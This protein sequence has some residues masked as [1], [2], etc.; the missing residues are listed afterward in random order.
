MRPNEHAFLEGD[1]QHPLT[2]CKWNG[3]FIREQECCGVPP[4]EEILLQTNQYYRFALTM[5]T[6]QI[7]T[8]LGDCDPV[9]VMPVP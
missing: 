9:I 5:Y 3:R 2:T 1:A 4:Y 6:D 8:R 7:T